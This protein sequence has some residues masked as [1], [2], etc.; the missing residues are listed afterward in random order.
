[1]PLIESYLR[2][3]HAKLPWKTREDVCRELRSLLYDQVEEKFGA[4]PTDLQIK[5][6]LIEFGSPAEVAARYR[7]NR[8]VIDSGWTDLYFLVV[9]IMIGALAIAFTTTFLVEYL[10]GYALRA[11]PLREAL[12]IPLSVLKASLAGIGS[13][14]VVFILLSRIFRKRGGPE[15]DWSPDELDISPPAG[16]KPSKTESIVTIV[17]LTLLIVLL[18]AYP[19]IVTT[20]ENLF[21]RSGIPLGHRIVVE[22][23]RWYV[24]ILSVFWA[25]EIALR[26]VVLKIGRGGALFAVGEWVLTGI[27]TAVAAVML[28]DPRLAVESGGWV[29]IKVI[30]VIVLAVGL[31]EFVAT[32]VKAI[33]RRRFD[34]EI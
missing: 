5:E 33:L 22:I 32:G 4:E 15:S 16:A 19:G 8:M 9:G 13:V 10:Q 21:A 6:T 34:G 26:L 29:G 3:I 28:L 2:A 17:F 7:G 24:V 31:A 18:N 14:T 25:A 23:F 27:T 1:M 12:R 11:V 20:A 30:V